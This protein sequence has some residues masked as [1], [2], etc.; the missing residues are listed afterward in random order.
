MHTAPRRA[1]EW[2]R[3]WRAIQILRASPDRIDQ[4]FEV[5]IALDGGQME[6]WFQRLLSEPEGPS[7]LEERPSLL[8]VLSDQQTLSRLP[9]GSLGHAYVELMRHT[10][11]GADGLSRAKAMVP[12]VAE[13]C[14]GPERQWFLERNGCTHDLLHCLTGYGQDW[15]GECAL[16]AFDH[17]LF[18]MRARLLGVMGV[19][20]S[21]PP[22]VY[23]FMYQAWRRGR[24]ARVPDS[25]RWEA[26]LR[27][28]LAEVRTELGIDP[29]AKAHPQGLLRGGQTFG[30]WRYEPVTAL[31]ASVVQQS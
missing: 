10:Q 28:P 6:D 1:I 31:Q 23:R 30:P 27:R 7:L 8:A 21:A 12:A 13:I 3:A 14:P 11:N 19:T 5:M 18:P 29:L 22:W 17:G 25:F 2:G 15:A 9:E 4:T 26:A 20:L 24:R 16:L